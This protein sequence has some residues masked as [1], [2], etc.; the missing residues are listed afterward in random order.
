MRNTLTA[1]FLL[2]AAMGAAAA[3]ISVDPSYIK[4]ADVDLKGTVRLEK[5]A[6]YLLKIENPGATDAVYDVS[7]ETCKDAGIKP[8]GGYSEFPDLNWFVF[9]STEVAVPAHSTGYLKYLE[10]TAPK[11]GRYE[12]SRWQLVLKTAQKT[13]GTM[14]MEVLL[15]VW[16]ETKLAKK[17][18]KKPERKNDKESI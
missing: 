7:L 18:G 16:I 17:P 1:V 3:G 12:N 11:T 10:I 14:N 15:P 4:F 8:N 6:G 9:R 13:A 2:L 5:K